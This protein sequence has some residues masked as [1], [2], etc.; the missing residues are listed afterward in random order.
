MEKCV[1]RQ[2]IKNSSDGEIIGYELL[3]QD[4]ESFYNSSLEAAAA[5]TII[6][7]LTENSGRLFND[8]KT[9]ITFTP[10]LLFRNTP[11]IFDSSKVVIQIEDS[12]I[13]HPLAQV[14]FERYQKDGYA[15]AI[16]DFQFT[17]KYFSL[18]EYV[19]YVK[20]DFSGNKSQRTMDSVDNI[21]KMAQGFGKK[22]IAVNVNSKEQYEL[23]KKIGVDY[24]E[25]SYIARTTESKISKVDYLQGNLFH[26]IIALSK[27][28]PDMGE[29]E[30][31]I[32][33]DVAL[34]YSLLKMANSPYFAA[35]HEISSTR[36]ALVTIGLN[37]LRQWVYILTFDKDT[38]NYEEL[39]KTSFLRATFGA[40]L[41]AE[42]ENKVIERQDAYMLGMF[43]T[44]D[45]MIDA[46]MSEILEDL[47][48]NDT[49]KSA[50]VSGE[51]PA[52]P[53]YNLILSYE[54]ADWKSV[55]K[56][57]GQLNIAVNE[58][59]RI[60]MACV[61]SVDEIWKELIIFK[62]EQP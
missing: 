18:L 10:S 57:A 2:A 48:I 14:I 58:L 3:M 61:D 20:V 7:F 40:K 4:G 47:P 59:A 43:S 38:Q 6:G 62:E 8:K 44:L 31:I 22:C 21:V 17:P 53:F 27:D 42:F 33:R 1:V 46:P 54:K 50:L 9:F 16:K 34:T 51:G 37:Q 52:A 13:V 28:E 5:G 60:Y 36:Q 12:I 15:L 41:A 24:V 55:Q 32:N 30:E 56:Y 19:D 29:I 39:M 49:I 45:S 11:K 23:A 25:G 26:L 35:R